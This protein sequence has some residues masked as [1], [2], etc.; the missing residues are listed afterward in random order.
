MFSKLL[1]HTLKG[2][3]GWST[4]DH[5]I[6]D[7]AK[8]IS[9]TSHKRLFKLWSVDYD[10]TLTIQYDEVHTYTSLNPVL[11]G[12]GWTLDSETETQRKITK[13]YKTLFDVNKEIKEIEH[14]QRMLE[15]YME[16]QRKHLFDKVKIWEKND[17]KK[18][19]N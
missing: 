15:K 13:R 16:S 6:L 17:D 12:K 1:F 14:K 8:I 9:V 18:K 11:G 5:V 3:C 10:Y 4:C 2:I 7:V 19:L